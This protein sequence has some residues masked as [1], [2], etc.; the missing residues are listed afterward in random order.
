MNIQARTR[1]FLLSF[2]LL[3]LLF[4]CC[5]KANAASQVIH[6]KIGEKYL[7]KHEPHLRLTENQ[8]R[9]FFLGTLFPDIRYIAKIPRTATHK[10]GM[11]LELVQR[12]RHLFEKGIKLHSWM[13]DARKNIVKKSNI[14]AKLKRVPGTLRQKKLFLRILEDEVLYSQKDWSHMAALTKNSIQEEENTGI[15]LSY[16]NNW[17]RVL[18]YS[19]TAP[20][21]E[22]LQFLLNMR[23]SFLRIPDEILQAWA[24]ILPHLA[25]D[26][27]IRKYVANLMHEF[28]LILTN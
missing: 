18:K 11:T 8:K 14:N 16:I 22:N 12:E 24:E 15:S 27:E 10:K 21:S 1:Y 17:H 2:V 4:G 5:I 7:E 20:P 9:A 26:P 25:K 6:A 19:F 13:D 23:V 28:D 3:G